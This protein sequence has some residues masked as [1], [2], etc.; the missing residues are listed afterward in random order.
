[1]YM[2]GSESQARKFRFGPYEL[3]EAAR[4]LRKNG[5]SIHLQDQ[6]WEIL[7]A[8]LQRPGE[9][10]SREELRRRLWPDG[11]FVDYDQSLNKAVNKLREAL[12][13]S[14]DRPRY[15]ETV[16]RRGY[17]FVAPV[18][19]ERPKPP[20]PEAPKEDAAPAKKPA[21]SHARLWWGALGLVTAAI[22]VTGLWPVPAP[23]ARATP[24]TH[25]GNAISGTLAVHGGR[26]LY[27]AFAEAPNQFTAGWTEFWSISTQGGEPR[28]ERMPFLNADPRCCDVLIQ[29]NPGQDTIFITT[30][31]T[32]A[33]PGALWLA[34]FDGSK[35]RRIGE[36]AADSYYF[37]SPDLKTLLRV[38]EKGLFVRPVDGGPERLLARIYV[39]WLAGTAWH[40]SGERILLEGM[41]GVLKYW[42]VKS[43]GT[44]LRLLLPGFQ[45]EQTMANWSPDGRR[46]YFSSQ[47][48]IF[49]LGSRRWL[50]WMRRPQ[51]QRLTAGGPV[52]YNFWACEDPADSRVIYTQGAV[53]RGELMKLNRQTNRFEPYLDKLSGLELDY[54]PD[55]QWIAYVSYP[56]QEL[57]KCRRDGSDKILLDDGLK[58]WYPRWSPDGKRLAFAA[59]RHLWYG[60]PPQIYT[61]PAAGGK[62][63]PVKGVNGPGFYPDHPDWSPD[64][65]KL[66]FAP[67]GY[68]QDVHVSIVD[69]ETGQV[70]MVP[71][72]E[73]MSWAR[74]SPDGK[75]LV[76]GGHGRTLIYDFETRSWTDAGK[77]IYG[78]TWSK[79]SK[80]VYGRTIGPPTRLVRIAVATRKLEEIRSVNEFH[81]VWL[82][83]SASWTPDGEAVVTADRNMSEIYRLDVEW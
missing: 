24:L 77:G 70:E 48:E 12:C 19:L 79:D 72:S 50:G 64:A 29:P 23:R 42:Q 81:L 82:G 9:V 61:I 76:A 54:S 80:Y 73:T 31:P 44:G 2:P 30:R 68:S 4:E 55:G 60:E 13:D 1:M 20:A 47:G 14:A 65:K 56:E 37:V 34:G 52:A 67:P 25:G 63:E 39:G 59:T 16:A 10:V 26:I 71:G 6:P 18:E 11:T 69:L 58:S 36:A 66:V 38:A 62:P 22:L 7:R 28:R 78:P 46:L 57:W 40:P 33:A 35:P 74:W 51:P 27:T 21:P 5:L 15:V 43:D 45:A 3:D 49:V 32:D 83:S 53:L 41:D 75:H 8:L 17:R